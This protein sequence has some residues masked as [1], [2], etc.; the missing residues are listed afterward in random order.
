M[1][2]APA[3]RRDTDP[4]ADTTRQLARVPGGFHQQH[5]LG[6]FPC[7]VCLLCSPTQASIKDSLGASSIFPFA[8][9][10]PEGLPWRPG[11]AALVPIHLSNVKEQSEERSL[12]STLRQIGRAHV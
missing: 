10:H 4:K 11:D 6:D 9:V 1:T 3:P 5:D 12:G 8:A 7:G 2:P